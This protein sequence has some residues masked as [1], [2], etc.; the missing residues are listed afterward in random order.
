MRSK[1]R[2]AGITI[3]LLIPT[4][5]L[6]SWVLAV[7]ATAPAEP[8][9]QLSDQV[10]PWQFV[11][12][13]ELP[14]KAWASI[15]PDE[16][17]FRRYEAPDRRPVWVY[18]GAYTGRAD[19]GKSA[20][21]PAECYPSAG[22]EIVGSRSLPLALP[23]PE[24]L[25]T[26]LIEVQR[27]LQRETVLY[28]FQPAGRWPLTPVAEEFYQIFDAIV[29]RPQY[30]FVRL[31]APSDGTLEAEQQLEEFAREI[32]W[33][34]RTAVSRFGDDDGLPIID[35]AREHRIPVL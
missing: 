11:A 4:A 33:P 8:L 15:Q 5:V 25:Q 1:L 30:A 34:V 3:A 29:G 23:G 10:G 28:W 7:N 35:A 17:L 14:A 18:V 9:Q 26:R 31:S 16:Y 24:I 21:D 6:W 32:A 12:E 2:L 27:G 13:Q 20:H 19:Y 22:F